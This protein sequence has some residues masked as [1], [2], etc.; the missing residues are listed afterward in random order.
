[1]QLQEQLIGDGGLDDAEQD[2]DWLANV[3]PAH[4]S[5]INF[6]GTFSFDVQPYRE[7]LFSTKRANSA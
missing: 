6:R 2:I 5:N 4:F 3:S 1:M 7:W